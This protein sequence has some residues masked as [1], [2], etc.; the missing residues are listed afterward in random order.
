[1]VLELN[2][3]TQKP[4]QK[5]KKSKKNQKKKKTLQDRAGTLGLERRFRYV[6]AAALFST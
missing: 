3:L 6:L 2:P 4:Q 1:L 5:I